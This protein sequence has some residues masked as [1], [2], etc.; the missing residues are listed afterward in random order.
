MKTFII[1]E[2][3][4]QLCELMLRMLTQA[5]GEAGKVLA[6][7]SFDWAVSKVTGYKD[8]AMAFIS[9]DTSF[10]KG[11]A[12]ARVIKDTAPAIKVILT[13]NNPSDKE[14]CADWG[15]DGF[16]CKGD[17]VPIEKLRSFLLANGMEL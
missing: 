6:L 14:V 3:D 13:S 4:Q 10:G 1:V 2:P 9:H 11:T 16:L 7:E 8:V 5:V 12:A 17:F 15:L